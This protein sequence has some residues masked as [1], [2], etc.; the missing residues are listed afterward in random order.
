MLAI[1]ITTKSLQTS[2]MM[3]R[4]WRWE[5]SRVYVQVF[6]SVSSDGPPV[7]MSISDTGVYVRAASCP[8]LWPTNQ[9]MN[10]W[11]MHAGH[12]HVCPAKV[13]S[14]N[15]DV[16]LN[17]KQLAGHGVAATVALHAFLLAADYLVV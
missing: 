13:A 9:P 10:V 4:P 8:F 15:V 3:T 11:L 1:R 7:Y 17:W 16:R 6:L 5:W 14:P 12:V 2:V